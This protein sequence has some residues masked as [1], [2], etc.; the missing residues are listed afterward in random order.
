MGMGATVDDG[1]P[2]S[3]LVSSGLEYYGMGL[4]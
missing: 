1:W 2:A 3:C 4:Q